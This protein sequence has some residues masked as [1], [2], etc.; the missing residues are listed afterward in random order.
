MI[1]KFDKLPEKVMSFEFNQADNPVFFSFHAKNK[2]WAYTVYNLE[3]KKFESKELQ[4]KDDEIVYKTVIS[5]GGYVAVSLSTKEKKKFAKMWIWNTNNDE[6]TQLKTLEED[7]SQLVFRKN[8]LTF[9]G[10]FHDSRPA[11]E[12]LW[13]PE[14]KDELKPFDLIQTSQAFWTINLFMKVKRIFRFMIANKIFRIRSTTKPLGTPLMA[15]G[16]FTVRASMNISRF[17]NTI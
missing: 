9:I 4:R 14:L 7:F 1:T 8:Y 6:L 17:Q 13:S 15:I 11:Q 12:Y 2:K 16:W 10:D 5:T 3:Q